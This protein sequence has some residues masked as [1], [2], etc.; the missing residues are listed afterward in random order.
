MTMT[1]QN[2]KKSDL[3]KILLIDSSFDVVTIEKEHQYKKII[4]FDYDSHKSLLNNNLEHSLSESYLEMSDLDKIETQSYQLM[5]WYEDPKIS[6]LLNYEGINLGQ[7]ILVE[8][9][10][11]LLSFLKI[12]VELSRIFEVH[13]DSNYYCT[14]SLFETM[15]FISKN[16]KKLSDK[17]HTDKFLYDAV[18]YNFRVGK[19]S[20][21]I[22]LSQET[23][24]KLKNTSDAFFNKLIGMRKYNPNNNTILLLNIDTIRYKKLLS[25]NKISLNIVLF[26]RR[27][28]TI[29]NLESFFLVK[30]SNCI[31][32]NNLSLVD[33]SVTNSINKRLDKLKHHLFTLEE[34]DQFFESLFVIDNRPF[35]KIIKNKLFALVERR[36]KE[37][38][39]EIEITK[40]LLSKYKFKS[41]LI[42]SETGFNEK[43]LT[44][45]ARSTD[46]K[47]ILLQHGLGYDT[48]ELPKGVRYLAGGVPIDS[49]KMVVWGASTDRYLKK[50]GIPDNKIEILGSPAHDVFFEKSLLP[51]NARY[52]LLTTSSPT[53]WIASDLKVETIQRYESAIRK[54]CKAT[55]SQNKKLV[56]KLHPDQDEMNIT[57]WIKKISSKISVEKFADTSELIRNC[58]Y[59]ITI[60]ISTVILEAQ[61]LKKPVIVVPVKK[62]EWGI[63]EVYSSNSCLITEMDDISNALKQ[64]DDEAF[65][66]ELI[67]RGSA[68]AS[69]YLINDG[70]ATQRLLEFFQKL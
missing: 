41:I 6:P 54:I 16:T 34:Q 40:K 13:G 18:Y 61:I 3:D 9:H 38:V 28:P 8:F 26:N 29:W 43:I 15:K 48:P 7:L 31:V 53:K 62:Y 5:R 50:I 49:S 36:F 55:L 22:K 52:V 4:T 1:G 66:N 64:I 44:S 37:A 19:I 60:D 56:V 11:F 63:P 68:F 24:L 45:I 10:H 21:A 51:K 35:W 65:R 32:E 17:Q 30:K 39:N 2:G 20:F 58:D 46:L 23:Y 12:F 27:R 33:K 59:M 57:S 69:Q 14:P 67:Q 42:L 70:N 47:I 25:S